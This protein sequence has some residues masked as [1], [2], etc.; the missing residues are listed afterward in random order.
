MVIENILNHLKALVTEKDPNEEY[1][2]NMKKI[3]AKLT[4]K[5]QK[6]EIQLEN[7]NDEAKRRHINLTLKV[8]YKQLKKG[9]K[10]I[11]ERNVSARSSKKHKSR[12]RPELSPRILIGN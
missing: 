12:V 3:L 9:E 1:N 10:I 2:A 11:H 8:M 4:D 6:L 5:A 7:E